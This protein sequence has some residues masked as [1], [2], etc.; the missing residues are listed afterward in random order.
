[1]LIMTDQRIEN[2]KRLDEILFELQLH[3]KLP[4]FAWLYMIADRTIQLSHDTQPST[5]ALLTGCI[6]HLQVIELMKTANSV[7]IIKHGIADRFPLGLI[8][9]WGDRSLAACNINPEKNRIIL[10][11][12]K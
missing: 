4:V 1:M 10:F 3:S 6:S 5:D 2:Q 9:A 11:T 12:A 8:L 7:E